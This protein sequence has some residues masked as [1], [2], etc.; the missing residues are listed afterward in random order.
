MQ[1]YGSHLIPYLVEDIDSLLHLLQRA[2]DLRLDLPG[3][4]H[5]DEHAWVNTPLWTACL[6]ARR[7][8]RPVHAACQSA[9]VALDYIAGANR[10]SAHLL[11]LW[12]GGERTA[13]RGDTRFT[14]ALAQHVAR[15]G[16]LGKCSASV[17]MSRDLGLRQGLCPAG[18][19]KA[20][21]D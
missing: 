1:P 6:H 3:C 13:D 18:D 16:D 17:G 5:A 15:N 11:T 4:T 9:H 19:F 7:H 10:H 8:Q 14:E 12:V 2:V 20:V 21:A